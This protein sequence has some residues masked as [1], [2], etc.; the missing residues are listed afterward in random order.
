MERGLTVPYPVELGNR[1]GTEMKL[2]GKRLSGKNLLADELSIGKITRVELVI[3]G[4]VLDSALGSAPP[5][6]AHHKE[7]PGELR[8]R[9][10]FTCGLRP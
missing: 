4:R 1:V 10:T 3:P 5:G 7:D 6:L 2:P 8:K 9:D